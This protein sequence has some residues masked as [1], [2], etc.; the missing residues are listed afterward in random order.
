MTEKTKKIRIF[1]ADTGRYIRIGVVSLVMGVV[2][3][4]LELVGL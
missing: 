1:L 2:N 3:W 4:M